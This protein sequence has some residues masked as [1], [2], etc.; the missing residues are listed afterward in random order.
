MGFGPI[1]RS[2]RRGVQSFPWTC[3]RLTRKGTGQKL[4]DGEQGEVSVC[5]FCFVR[6]SRGEVVWAE[7]IP[8]PTV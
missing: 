3:S 2:E 1:G 6:P 5:L 4:Q 7:G 8:A